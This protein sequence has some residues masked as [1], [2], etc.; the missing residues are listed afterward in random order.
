[1]DIS[2][3]ESLCVYLYHNYDDLLKIACNVPSQE[4]LFVFLFQLERLNQV[5]LQ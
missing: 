1:M 5:Y 3:I 2:P 4:I